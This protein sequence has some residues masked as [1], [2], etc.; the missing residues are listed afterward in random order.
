MKRSTT[1]AR[2]AWEKKLGPSLPPSPT[3]ESSWIRILGKA[4]SKANQ[5][6]VRIAPD[7]WR[8]IA[9]IIQQWRHTHTGAS[10]WISPTEE[11][12]AYEEMAAVQIAAQ[13]P[14]CFEGQLAVEV[15]LFGQQVDIDN[16][17]KALLD[18]LQKSGVI[19]NDRQIV[20]LTVEKFPAEEP[21]IDMKVR[22]YAQRTA[23]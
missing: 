18:S 11:V 21:H 16:A 20:Q 1:A 13:E 4:P 12:A 23:P 19:K 9:S 2:L 14:W 17:L 15:H 3:G 10:F 7:L 5:H 6:V 22:T 8:R